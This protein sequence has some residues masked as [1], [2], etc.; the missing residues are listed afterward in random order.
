MLIR[1]APQMGI[2]RSDVRFVVHYSLPLSL[3]SYSQQIVSARVN[4]VW[5]V[6]ISS[7]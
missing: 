5:L 6:S 4:V 7:L 3:A 2:D 1:F